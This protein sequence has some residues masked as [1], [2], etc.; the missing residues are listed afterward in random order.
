MGTERISRRSTI[1]VDGKQRVTIASTGE[2]ELSDLAVRNRS[3]R[4]R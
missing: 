2:R 3:A 4:S 1:S